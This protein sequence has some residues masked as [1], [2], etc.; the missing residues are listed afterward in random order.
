[1]CKNK[2]FIVN[3]VIY[4]VILNKMLVIICME[5]SYFRGEI[6]TE[7]QHTIQGNSE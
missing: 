6:K 3:K 5:L 1:M 4:K 7:I 2:V